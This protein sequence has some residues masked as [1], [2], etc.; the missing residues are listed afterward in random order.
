[1]ALLGVTRFGEM[2]ITRYVRLRLGLV[3]FD[4]IRIFGYG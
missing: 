3:G 1:M 2:R 4:V